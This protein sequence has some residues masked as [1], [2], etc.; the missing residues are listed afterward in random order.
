MI[1]YYKLSQKQLK[2]LNISIKNIEDNIYDLCYPLIIDDTDNL[3]D[4]IRYL[5][6][7]L[8]IPILKYSDYLNSKT[9]YQMPDYLK[10]FSNFL[11]IN[12][13]IEMSEE[14]KLGHALRVGK[15][16][17]ELAKK[18]NL[19]E[20]KIK[21]LYIASLFHDVG[22][23]KLPKE[24]ISKKGRLTDKEFSI[25]KTHS[26]LARE[27]LGNFFNE[28]ILSI[29]ESH[30]ERMDGSG[31]SK[32]IFPPL[33]VQILG[34]ADSYDAMTSKRVYQNSK[35]KQSAFDELL[36][37]TKKRETGGKGVLYNPKLVDLFIKV[38]TSS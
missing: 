6:E 29:V 3:P 35:T 13:S 4:D 31:Y 15:Y 33:E 8:E 11:K 14:E 27:V 16:A 36:L 17:L 18:L 10:V 34:I 1:G 9:K 25:I 38:Q 28:N 24:I 5:Y 30:H 19:E 37:C 7:M 26:L 20:E 21:D 22:K 32:G 2:E 23:S 12:I